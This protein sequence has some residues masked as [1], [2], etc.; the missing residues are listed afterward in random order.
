MKKLKIGL[1]LLLAAVMLLGMAGAGWGIP[2]GLINMQGRLTNNPTDG[3]QPTAITVPTN[4]RFNL[5]TGPSGGSP[6]WTET[7]DVRPD[8][9]GVFNVL[10]GTRY[11]L[12]NISVV[13]D[14]YYLEI[15][16]E[17]SPGAFQTLTPRQRLVSVP[18]AITAKNVRGGTVVATTNLESQ[19]AISGINTTTTYGYGVYGETYSTGLPAL[20]GAA[21]VT[22]N[23]RGVGAGVF[24]ISTG[25]TGVMG[26]GASGGIYGSTADGIG[27]YGIS[28]GTATSADPS[29]G[30][31][32][33]GKNTQATIPPGRIAA[34]GVYGESTQGTG[35]YGYVPQYLSGTT[36]NTN[37]NPAAY[38]YNLSPAGGA[39]P[40]VKGE[41][42][43]GYGVYGISSG[44]SRAGVYGENHFDNVTVSGVTGS[45]RHGYG[46]VGNSTYFRGLFGRVANPGTTG[47]AI[48]AESVIE[49]GTAL[50]ILRGGIKIPYYSH[51]FS[52][53]AG[54]AQTATMN[55]QKGKITISQTSGAG[56]FT[57]TVN[58]PY[59]NAN[60]IFILGENSSPSGNLAMVFSG[61]IFHNIT[62]GSFQL[63]GIIA[64]GQTVTLKFLII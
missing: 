57:I 62:S 36:A 7:Q 60:S 2:S 18:F 61:P 24:G 28:A 53:I 41:S 4:C 31:G 11:S 52:N 43:K 39:N 14:S 50:Q 15:Q 35:V 33:V 30:A 40:G 29:L 34:P 49:G 59:V 32:A 12:D 20:F 9:N 55:A 46:V 58:N 19:R 47:A 63:T 16:A 37:T 26:S 54:T 3:S 48:A 44:S 42:A 13:D 10:L 45:S 5:Y 8:S 56:S 6:I 22:G 51:T 23:N 64:S 25:G 27:I 1:G 21:G 17:A 38:G